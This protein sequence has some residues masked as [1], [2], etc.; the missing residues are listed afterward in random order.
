MSASASTHFVFACGPEWYAVPAERAAEVVTFETLTRIPAAPNHVMGVFA[1]RGEV[2]PV[3]D[4]GKLRSGKSEQT[5]R[6]VILRADRGAYALTLTRV[7]GVEEVVGRPP[8]LGSEGLL[9]H[10]RGPLKIKDRDVA[11]L[12]VEGLFA[13]LSG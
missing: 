7:S 1:H 6:A 11:L 10:L 5:S 3:I 13:L 4:L 8:H 2:I 12:D 9:A